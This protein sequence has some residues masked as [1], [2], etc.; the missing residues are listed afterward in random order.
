[1]DERLSHYFVFQSQSAGAKTIQMLEH[2]GGNDPNDSHSKIYKFY[3]YAAESSVFNTQ[4]SDNYQQ[5]TAR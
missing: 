4:P 5:K 1:L 3:I 2:Q